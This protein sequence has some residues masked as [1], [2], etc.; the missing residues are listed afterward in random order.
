MAHH[1]NHFAAT[2]LSLCTYALTSGLLTCD[3]EDRNDIIYSFI[4]TTVPKNTKCFTHK[5]DEQLSL[6]K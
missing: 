6:K 1:K 4:H 3:H 2:N 5:Q